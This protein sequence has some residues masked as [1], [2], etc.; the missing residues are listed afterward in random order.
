MTTV[1]IPRR[2]E[3]V[4][5]A[6]GLPEGTIALHKWGHGTTAYTLDGGLW[7]TSHGTAV[8]HSE[9]IGWPALVPVE[10]EEERTWISST[11]TG[12][13]HVGFGATFDTPHA[14]LVTP[15]ESVTPPRQ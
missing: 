5:D 4:A 7:V 2:I 10:A 15:W 11:I 9:V 6:E 3:T 12:S 8:P 1:Y 13:M 14:R